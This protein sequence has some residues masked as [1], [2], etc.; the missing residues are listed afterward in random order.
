MRRALINLVR[1][2]HQIPVHSVDVLKTAIVTSIGLFELVRMPFGLK[3]SVRYDD[4]VEGSEVPTRPPVSL[5]LLHHHVHGKAQGLSEG[6]IIHS[7]DVHSNWERD[8]VA[9]I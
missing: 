5:R 9:L 1:P 7:S 6:R 3:I 2:Y 4:I 8:L